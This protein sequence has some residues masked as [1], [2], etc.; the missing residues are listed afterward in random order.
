M[1]AERVMP[2]M[3]SRSRVLVEGPPTNRFA[4]ETIVLRTGRPVLTVSHDEPL[5]EFR[6]AESEVWRSRLIKARE[7]ITRATRAVGRVE[8][9]NHPSLDWLGTGWLVAPNVIVT[10][11]HVA[12]E[13]GRRGNQGFVFRQ[14]RGGRLAASIDFLEEVGRVEELVF[15]VHEIL[16]IEDDD[17]PDIALLRVEQASSRRLAEPVRLADWAPEQ[18]RLV[19]AIGYPARDS[20]IPDQDLMDTIFGNVY[21]KKRLAPG[22]ISRI[23]DGLVLHDC[24]TLGGNSGSV[25][26]DLDT[27]QAVALH[28]AGRFLEANFAVPSAIIASRLDRLGLPGTN[29]D[30]PRKRD[31]A[32]SQPVRAD[33]DTAPVPHAPATGPAVSLGN[34]T[35]N[36]QSVTIPITVTV[37]IGSPTVRAAAGRAAGA[38]YTQTDASDLGTDDDELFDEEAVPEDYDD[39]RGYE[40]DFLGS[41][42]DVPLPE[43][44]KSSVKADVLT[45]EVKGESQHVLDYEHFSVM[46]SK[47]R[48]MC[49]FSAA[50]IDGKR[51]KKLKRVGWRTDPRIPSDA[52]ISK[53]CYG[54][55]PKFSRGHM[56]R[57]EDPVWGSDDD[58]ELGNAD[59]MHV[60]NAVPQMQSFNAGIWLGLED[61][62]LDHAREDD[63][64]IS[65]FTGPFLRSND[66]IKFGVQIPRS[67]WKIIAFIHDETGELSATGYTMS[68]ASFLNENEFVFGQH[69]TSQIPI[70]TIESRTGLRFGDLTDRDPLRDQEEGVARPLSDF[71]EIRF[72]QRSTTR[73]PR[74][75]G[76]GGGRRLPRR[77]QPTVPARVYGVTDR[78]ARQPAA[79]A[80]SGNPDHKHYVVSAPT[81]FTA[82]SGRYRDAIREFGTK[83]AAVPILASIHEDA[84]KLVVLDDD[85]VRDLRARY[86]SL[87]IEPNLRYRLARHPI[88]DGFQE[89]TLAASAA[90]R[91]VTL[92]VV[93]SGTRRPVPNADV[94]ASVN[95]SGLV[96]FRGRT[97]INGQVNFR[98]GASVR[99]FDSVAVVPAHGYWN[100]RV[101]SVSASGTPVIEVSP[102][103]GLIPQ[104]YD[105]GH[106]YSQ[107]FDGAARGGQN[108]VVGVLDTGIRN[109]HPNLKPSG[110]VNSVFNEPP[111]DWFRDETGHGTHCAGVIAAIAHASGIKGYAPS[112]QLRAYR[113]FAA[114]AEGAT[115][116]DIAHAIQAAVEDKCDVLSMSLGSPSAQSAIRNKIELAYDNGV[117]CVAATGND[118]SSVSYPAAFPNVFGVAAFGQF[119]EYPADSISAESESTLR[120]ADGKYFVANF[121]NY[122]DQSVDFCAPG[123]SVLSTVPGG[124]ASWDGTSMACPHVAGMAALAFAARPE[125]LGAQRDASRVDEIEKVLRHAA[126]SMGFGGVYEGSGSLSVPAVLEEHSAMAAA[127]LA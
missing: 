27:G 76:G 59:S 17:G 81:G 117:V 126:R 97:D 28:F 38:A 16:H 98:I 90:T 61:Y 82:A 95:P 1:E 39:R 15:R 21:E 34:G 58:A 115:T 62:A 101:R 8:V 32:P 70:S 116:F 50:N 127:A 40:P 53:E 83:E 19:A 46:M 78:C 10:N 2:Q 93:E 11:R 56:T 100:R 6:D 102:L 85:R 29:G 49:L 22:Q 41:D 110:G 105:W 64:R 35:H 118:G 48:R 13:F 119:G 5:L 125:I 31:R 43:A 51:S 75:G 60:T 99:R 120:S 30:G 4:L 87:T 63:M 55:P 33:G 109:D 114:G 74:P 123:V 113:V 54:N 25:V 44:V 96:G 103:P 57:R 14:G 67:F 47:S 122:G 69:E 52:Q 9:E 124:Y 73:G 84:D 3:E 86:P 24:S 88:L 12:G 65:V 112:I 45:F 18:G 68:Q 72:V 36:G 107:M 37:D 77:P 91:Q 111:A 66:P 106:V 26:L 121:S 79:T 89:L 94:Y 108:V 92:R 42:A 23:E 71:R 80:S 104:R 20:R 7:R